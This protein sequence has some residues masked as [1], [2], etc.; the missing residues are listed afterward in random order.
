MSW[1]DWFWYKDSTNSPGK[2]G[3]SRE[4]EQEHPKIQ[5]EAQGYMGT[6]GR[7]TRS[8]HDSTRSPWNAT[9]YNGIDHQHP[10]RADKGQ[11]RQVT[12]RKEEA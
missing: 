9:V 4:M 1:D 2:A 12:N 8:T 10:R 6:D 11:G 5:G 7:T 3:K